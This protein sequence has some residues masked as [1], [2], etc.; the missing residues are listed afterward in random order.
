MVV[1]EDGA[2]VMAD[3]A[4]MVVMAAEWLEPQLLIW[5][6]ELS[7]RTRGDRTNIIIG[8][9]ILGLKTTLRQRELAGLVKDGT[10]IKPN[11][12]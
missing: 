9:H 6:W 11:G 5:P 2:T 8:M 3:T 4:V 7:A 12:M 1:R 10:A